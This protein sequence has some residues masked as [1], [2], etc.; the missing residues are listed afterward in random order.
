[1]ITSVLCRRGQGGR[2]EGLR[3]WPDH[4]GHVVGVLRPGYGHGGSVAGR[5]RCRRRRSSAAAVGGRTSHLTGIEP[6]A[7][8]AEGRALDAAAT[9]AEPSRS[10]SPPYDAVHRP[11]LRRKLRRTPCREHACCSPVVAA[12]RGGRD[13]NRRPV[14]RTAT[15]ALLQTEA[16]LAFVVGATTLA[17]SRCVGHGLGLSTSRPVRTANPTRPTSTLHGPAKP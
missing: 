5:R 3:S 6:L 8:A 15:E 14:Q 4:P 9:W 10:R 1:M 16:D 13:R 17:L 7:E 2:G 11:E 12:T